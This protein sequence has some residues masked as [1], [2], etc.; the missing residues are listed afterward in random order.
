MKKDS[1]EILENM[2]ATDLIV[3]LNNH[4]KN[5]PKGLGRYS[6]IHSMDDDLWWDTLCE[7]LGAYD[8]VTKVMASSGFSIKDR[9]FY[10]DEC[11]AQF[12]SFTSKADIVK[13]IGY[14]NL[15]EMIDLGEHL[16]KTS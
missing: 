5:D 3:M 4:I 2:F 6:T 14:E 15:I 9:Y 8:I 13:H 16:E 11:T 10:Y 1:L 7:H 12:Y